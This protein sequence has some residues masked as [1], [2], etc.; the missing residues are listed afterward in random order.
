MQYFTKDAYKFFEDLKN[1]NSKEWFEANRARWNDDVLKPA[2]SFIIAVG[3]KLRDNLPEIKAIPKI[4]K[5]I[6]RIHRDVRFSKNKEPYKTNLGLYFWEGDRPKIECSGFY[7]HIEPT[8]FYAGSG[9]Y[10]FPK[11]IIKK[12]REAL[13]K[14]QVAK[15][16]AEI[17]EKILKLKKYTI[18]GKFYKKIPAG[19]KVDEKYK[20]FLLYNG[21][22]TGYSLTNAN[23]FIKTK[24]QVEFVVKIFEDVLPIHN[25]FM[26][27]IY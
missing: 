10:I 11:D 4:D 12:F 16:L 5:S 8:S 2:E 25:W 26:E 24:D 9:V 21:L 14:E 3:E 7:L 6:F 27:N 1:N 18:D 23:E 15:E 20:D 22:Y 17:T 19:Y 13:T